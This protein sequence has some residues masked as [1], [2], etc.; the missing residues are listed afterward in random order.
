MKKI[1][2]Y[3][4]H[5]T[6]SNLDNDILVM[7]NH[8][9]KYDLEGVLTL[10][11]YFPLKKSGLSNYRLFHNIQK[12]D[13]VY[14]LASLDFQSYYY[15]H[16]NEIK[17]LLKERKVLGVKIY[18]GY[19]HIDLNSKEFEEV[20]SLCNSKILMFHTGYCHKG[21][22]EAFNPIALESKIKKYK[23]INFILSHLGNPFV[24][25][26]TYLINTYDNVFTDVSGLIEKVQDKQRA[27]KCINY[28]IENGENSKIL[29]GTDY[30]IQ[31]FETTFE[32]VGKNEFIYNNRVSR[33]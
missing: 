28:I 19:Q 13:K 12:I 2:D 18:T 8:I 20:L 25:D 33:K 15:Q 27:K 26:V 32:L 21:Q 3:H 29:F 5:L 31:D 10:A 9:S 22:S 24:E 11:S 4:Y 7:K 6:N 30:P 14:M 23:E 16:L 1:F 17:S